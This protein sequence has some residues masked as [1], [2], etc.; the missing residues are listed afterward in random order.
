MFDD[1]IVLITGSNGRIGRICAETVLE[2]KGKV[3]LFDLHNSCKI[4]ISEKYKKNYIYYQVDINEIDLL[5]KS[6]IDFENKI[7]KINSAIHA[8]YPKSKNWGINFEDLNQK[9]LFNNLSF[10]LGGAI[11]F[12]Q[13]I[14]KKFIDYGGGNLI[15]ISSIQGLGAPK[16]DHYENTNMTS[17][18]EYNAIKSGIISV[19]KYLAKY[20]GGKNIR[21]NCISPG[22]ILDE[23]PISFK[24]KYKMDCNSKGLLDAKDL[25]GIIEFLLSNKSLY[26][27]GQN[28]VID[29][30]W[31]L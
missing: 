15:H 26:I 17:P 4:N 22:G 14:I 8:A 3:A 10:Q 5:E 7:G 25:K 29:D 21:V 16:F 23:Q 13:L 6:I 27:S 30:G 31:S 11:M 19:T 28:I 12:S 18:I 9:D 24:K 2:N 1:K 20:Y